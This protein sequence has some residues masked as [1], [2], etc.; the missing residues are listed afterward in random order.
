MTALLTARDI[1]P[2]LGRSPHTIGR[3]LREG[4]L[5]AVALSPKH[6][7]YVALATIDG[8]TGQSHRYTGPERLSQR[9]AAAWLGVS[10]ATVHRA[11][12]AGYVP[13]DETGAVL[14]SWVRELIEGAA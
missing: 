6:A 8:L 14:G 4:R 12:A 7:R 2:I 9:H 5:P 1:A 13:V 10:P 3:W 11:V